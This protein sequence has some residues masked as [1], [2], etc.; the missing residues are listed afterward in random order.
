MLIGRT[1]ILT[2]LALIAFASNSLLCRVALGH[3]HIDPA[4]FTGL[5]VGSGALVLWLLASLERDRRRSP[6]LRTRPTRAGWRSGFFLFA[7]AI[8]FSFAYVTLTAATGALILFAAVQVT[9]VAGAMR[10]GERLRAMEWLGLAIALGGLAYLTMP[11]LAAPPAG[12][13]LLMALAGIAWGFYTLRGRGSV[14][15]LA[16]TARNFLCAVAPSL[17]VVVLAR[18]DVHVS[19]AG[20]VWALASGMVAS[21]GG[22]VIWYAALRGLTAARAALVQLAVPVIAALGAVVF[23][24]ETVS[25]RLVTAACLILGGIALA[26]TRRP[27]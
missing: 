1:V 9:V 22:Y 24:S 14:A 12:G 7:Y 16:D 19:R 18:D 8:S 10:S 2:V 21:G 5:R 15:P 13:S 25:L 26:L 6:A 27:R 4:A 11:G 17:L 3:G 20:A 23:L